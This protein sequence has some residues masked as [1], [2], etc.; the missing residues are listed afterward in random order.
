[1][2]SAKRYAEP[3]YY[4]AILAVFNLIILLPMMGMNMRSSAGLWD[5]IF[6]VAGVYF[7]NKFVQYM[8]KAHEFPEARLDPSNVPEIVEKGIYR[9]VRHPVG[10]ALIYLNIACVLFARSLYLISVIPVFGAMWY[11]LALWE[12]KTMMD[13]FGDEYR[14]YSKTAGMFRGKGIDSQRLSSSG[15]DLY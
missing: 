8:R 7:T 2:S 10:A 9:E 1:M 12:E 4:P 15:Y 11:I 5:F 14:E 3:Y 13:R 6:V